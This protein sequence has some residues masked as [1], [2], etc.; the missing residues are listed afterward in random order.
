MRKPEDYYNDTERYIDKIESAWAKV[1][2]YFRT[3]NHF[4]HA[5]GS[6]RAR[7]L[8]TIHTQLEVYR[9]RF[10]G[11]QDTMALLHAISVCAEENLP[12][13]TWLAV[14]YQAALSKFLKPGGVTS[15]D[16][17]FY[18]PNLPTSTPSKTVE[19]QYDWQLGCQVYGAVWDIVQAETSITSIDGALTA[20]LKRGGSKVGEHVYAF[21]IGK[22]KARALL[23]MVEKNQLEFIGEEQ[24]LSRFLEKRRKR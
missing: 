2:L 21:K 13:P 12:L 11:G 5:E 4:G 10:E 3:E 20:V 16:A 19:S 7:G 6:E 8:L 22:T 14:S 18:S 15:L 24:A 17:V 1:A 23:S 9:R